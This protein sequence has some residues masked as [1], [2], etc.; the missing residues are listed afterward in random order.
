MKCKCQ[1][2][3]HGNSQWLIKHLDLKINH[4]ANV[5]VTGALYYS[6]D[7]VFVHIKPNIYLKVNCL[8]E[9]VSFNDPLSLNIHQ[10][11]KANKIYTHQKDGPTHSIPRLIIHSY[12][13][14]HPYYTYVDWSLLV[15]K[16]CP[17]GKY[18]QMHR[19]N[20]T[21]LQIICSTLI[22]LAT[23]TWLDPSLLTHTCPSLFQIPGWVGFM[24]NELLVR[25]HIFTPERY[26]NDWM[27]KHIYIYVKVDAEMNKIVNISNF[28]LWNPPHYN[29]INPHICEKKH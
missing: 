29:I 12:H 21:L 14:G 11:K 10:D 13:S 27:T 24:T 17:A 6:I 18:W 8:C 25:Y 15:L 23:A 20:I 4:L 1:S 7:P 3:K 9:M 16:I 2:E 26:L 5:R 19:I 22:C 28:P